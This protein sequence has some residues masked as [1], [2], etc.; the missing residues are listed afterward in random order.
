MDRNW[1]RID[2]P[3]FARRLESAERLDRLVVGT[4]DADFVAGNPLDFIRK[5]QLAA[6]FE[7]A[8]EG[9]LF[10]A[11]DAEEPP[12]M[13]GKQLDL[14][15]LGFGLRVPLITE[16]NNEVVEIGGGFGGQDGVT[17]G[18][19]MGGAIGGGARLAFRCARSGGVARVFPVGFD[20][21]AGGHGWYILPT[22][23]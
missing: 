8:R 7:R 6:D 17:A 21:F 16:V 19:G 14:L 20:L 1:V 9:V 3:S 12:P 15:R 4:A 5:D 11:R 10:Q 23:G 18:E 22:S 13:V 2:I